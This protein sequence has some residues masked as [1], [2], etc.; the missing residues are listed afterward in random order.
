MVK[1][2]SRYT[3]CQIHDGRRCG[4]GRSRDVGEIVFAEKGGGVGEPA[5]KIVTY[6]TYH[7]VEA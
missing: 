3:C 6:H 5:R 1:Q 7:V 4:W 2:L